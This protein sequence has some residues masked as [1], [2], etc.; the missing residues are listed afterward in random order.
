MNTIGL[1]FAVLFTIPTLVITI[2][3]VIGLLT[4]H[5]PELTTQQQ[6]IEKV[7]T[8]EVGI[9]IPLTIPIETTEEKEEITLPEQITEIYVT[10]YTL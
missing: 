3:M 1:T 8:K 6:K 7:E 4:P 2:P 9:S 10:S 5:Q